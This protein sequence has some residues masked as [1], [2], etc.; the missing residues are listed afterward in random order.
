MD[1]TAWE[2]RLCTAIALHKAFIQLTQTHTPKTRF[3]F[4]AICRAFVRT[5]AAIWWWALALQS[6][7]KNLDIDQHSLVKSAWGWGGMKGG[8]NILP[9]SLPASIRPRQLSKNT[10]HASRSGGS[11]STRSGMDLPQPQPQLASIRGGRL[12]NT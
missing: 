8:C 7:Q 4:F 6:L 11:S 1:D 5:P 3:F 9:V 10:F 12:L 2:T